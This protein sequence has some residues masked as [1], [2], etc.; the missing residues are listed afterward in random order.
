MIPILRVTARS[1]AAA[2]GSRTRRAAE[3]VAPARIDVE[4]RAERGAAE[5]HAVDHALAIDEPELSGERRG[6]DPD[7]RLDEDP[8]LGHSRGR[9]DARSPSHLGFHRHRPLGIPAV[10]AHVEPNAIARQLTQIV[11]VESARSRPGI[12]LGAEPQDPPIRQVH[13]LCEA[14]QQAL[15]AS[16][17]ARSQ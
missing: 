10:E 6:A 8:E 1:V 3:Q 5:E 15:R 17:Q 9:A 12:D 16:G 13:V 14:D 7:P 11:H 2:H 4:T